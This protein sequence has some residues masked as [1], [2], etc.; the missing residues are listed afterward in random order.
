MIGLKRTLTTGGSDFATA[1][2]LELPTDHPRPAGQS[3]LGDRLPFS[4]SPELSAKLRSFNRGANATPFMTLLTAYQVLLARIA[5]HLIV[6]LHP[7]SPTG[8]R[9]VEEHD[10]FFV[11][12][13]P[14]RADLSE[15]PSS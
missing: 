14:L 4:L 15:R 5:G 8:T 7:Q 11:N 12:T 9:R 13:L 1:P 3:H 6:S 10:G 2:L